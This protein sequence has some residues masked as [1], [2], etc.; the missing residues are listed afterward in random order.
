[1]KLVKNQL[2]TWLP[3]NGIV[4]VCTCIHILLCFDDFQREVYTLEFEF[5]AD[6]G[7]GKVE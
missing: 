5:V 7:N 4:C 2:A 1:M 3:L 6:K